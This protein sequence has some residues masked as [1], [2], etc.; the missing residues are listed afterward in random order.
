MAWTKMVTFSA[1]TTI[2]RELCEE[3][4]AAEKK[5]KDIDDAF[6]TFMKRNETV[7]RGAK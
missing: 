5:L 7:N 1:V 2:I 4:E 6:N 3:L